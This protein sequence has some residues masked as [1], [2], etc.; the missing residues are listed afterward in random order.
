[1]QV[2]D[3]M[4]ARVEVGLNAVSQHPDGELDVVQ[5]DGLARVKTDPW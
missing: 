4:A 2:V 3:M 1:M 5:K